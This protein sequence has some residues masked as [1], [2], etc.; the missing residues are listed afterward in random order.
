MF[1]RKQEINLQLNQ[2]ADAIILGLV[3]WVTHALRYYDI[4]DLS[5]LPEIPPFA[6][7][8]WV[9]AI[10]VPFG[11]FFL[12]LQGFYQYPLEKNIAKS[13]GQIMQA[14]FWLAVLIGI[15]ALFLRL[16]IPSRTVIILFVFFA[17]IALL[18]KERL[19]ISWYTARLQKEN[20][21]EPILLAGEMAKIREIEA[22]LNPM[23]RLEINIMA[24]IDLENAPISRL[25][26]AIHKHS[27]GRVILAFSKLDL[28]YVQRAIQT[29]EIEGVE[30]WLAADFIKT[31]VARPTYEHFASRPMLVFRTTPELSWELLIKEVIDRVGAFIGIVLLS[32]IFLIAA[33]GVRLSSPGPILFKQQRAGRHGKPFLMYKFRSMYRDAEQRKAELDALNQ[34]SGPVFKIENDPRV[35]PFG[36]FLRR[37][38]IDEFPQ[39]FNVLR[40]EMSLVG[41]RPLPVYE[42]EQFEN[43]AHRRRL[44]VKPGLTCLWQI[45]GRSRVT[46]FEDW[47]RL[48][49]QYI[50]NWSLWLDFVILLRTIPA[51][52][53]CR[54]AH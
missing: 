35:T 32:P 22:N 21:G 10:I 6:H 16:E 4:L 44:S 13:L 25:T 41:P 20:T 19:L 50:D 39:L 54:G 29:C 53:F 46:S 24:R 2:L 52:L 38:S 7:F 36:R 42:V 14:G 3:F 30:A 33:I 8:L 12:E 15:C 47:V 34:M 31:S 17:V 51:V 26:E 23:Q 37:T 45:E 9:L 11:P 18:L 1:S 27:V 49:L 28:D 5:M 48:D 43:L 40:G